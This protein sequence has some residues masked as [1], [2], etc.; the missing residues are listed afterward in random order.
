MGEEVVS[1]GRSKV[2]AARVG[3]SSRGEVGIVQRGESFRFRRAGFVGA[4]WLVLGGGRSWV[5]GK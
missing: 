4:Q 3:C 1:R 5:T 2:T